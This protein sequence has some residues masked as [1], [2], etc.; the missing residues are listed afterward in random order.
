MLDVA[1]T[2]KE[3]EIYNAR[4][5]YLLAYDYLVTYIDTYVR[6]RLGQ[7]ARGMI[8]LDINE[9]YEREIEKIT[10]FR[11][12]GVPKTH[13]L[14]RVVEFTYPINSEKHPMIQ[15]SDLIIFCIRK[16]FEI[17][18]GYHEEYSS[19]ARLFYATCFEK[20]YGRVNSKSLVDQTGIYAND[21]NVLLNR[22]W[23]KPSTGWKD[24]YQIGNK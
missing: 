23:L 22:M 13:R 20:I 3:S 8:I 18:K 1:A 12:V 14:K 15:F 2:G 19:A 16:F 5:P 11:R 7:S 21:V 6:T 10:Q 4:Q 17:E 9:Q 24:K